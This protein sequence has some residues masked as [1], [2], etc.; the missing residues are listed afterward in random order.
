MAKVW[1]PGA[2]RE[3]VGMFI[4]SWCERRG[5][6]WIMADNL[7]GAYEVFCRHHRKKDL[8][9]G[10]FADE[11]NLQGFPTKERFG[12]AGFEGLGLC[13]MEDGFIY[14]QY[15]VRPGKN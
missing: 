11:M 8:T 12:A 5:S 3:M 6:A 10:E 1:K 15:G 13:Y 9:F 2:R 7:F 4:E 14:R